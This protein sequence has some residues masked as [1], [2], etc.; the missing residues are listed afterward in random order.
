M[1]ELEKVDDEAGHA[2]ESVA[3][4]VAEDVASEDEAADIVEFAH[5]EEAEL[6]SVVEVED[7]SDH[8]L[9]DKSVIGFGNVGAR[10]GVLAAVG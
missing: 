1:D 10:Q 4:F 7:S 3:E 6:E 5:A 9:V 2:I 8:E